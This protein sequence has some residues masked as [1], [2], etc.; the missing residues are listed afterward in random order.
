MSKPVLFSE[1]WNQPG[2]LMQDLSIIKELIFDNGL[3]CITSNLDFLFCEM[4]YG[5]QFYATAALELL[6]VLLEMHLISPSEISSHIKVGLE[7]WEPAVV[8][9]TTAFVQRFQIYN[10]AK[11][12]KQ[13][14]HVH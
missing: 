5:D 12:I 2:F 9:N 10:H 8:T 3:D 11:S 7:H 13:L 14:E 6:G 1:L 4:K